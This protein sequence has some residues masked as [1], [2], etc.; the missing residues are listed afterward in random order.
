[1]RKIMKFVCNG[2]VQKQGQ[3]VHK[4]AAERQTGRETNIHVHQNKE[5]HK[6]GTKR[7][8]DRDTK[9]LKTGEGQEEL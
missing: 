7:Q 6:K 4:T 1:M 2:A 5:A 9:S 3:T 8:T